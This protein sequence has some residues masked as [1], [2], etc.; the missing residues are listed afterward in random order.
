MKDLAELDTVFN[1]SAH[2]RYQRNHRENE[3]LRKWTMEQMD[4]NY[5]ND[6]EARTFFSSKIPF[7]DHFFTRRLCF[8]T[9]FLLEDKNS[10]WFKFSMIAF[11]ARLRYQCNH[12]ENQFSRNWT[13][14]LKLRCTV[15]SLFVSENKVPDIKGFKFGSPTRK[16]IPSNDT[17]S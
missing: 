16:Q 1:A 11:V 4:H 3:S 17:N 9:I 8:A 15:L 12:R 10:R 14:A 13:W 7:L 2:L 6:I 5:L